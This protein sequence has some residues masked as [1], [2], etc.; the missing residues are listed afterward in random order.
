MPLELRIGEI[1]ISGK[2][3]RLILQNNEIGIFD[4]K[5]G[6]PATKNEVILGRDPQL[7]VAA[8]AL[9]EGAFNLEF[10]KISSLNYW[11]LSAL[12]KS[13]IKK[14]CGDSE[15]ITTLI[16]AAKAGLTKLFEHFSKQENGYISAPDKNNYQKNEYW[17]LARI[18]D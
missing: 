12:S 3:D 9:V 17:H 14:I 15:E 10:K 11:K 16:Y 1:L 2:V 7:T 18:T 8:L 6:L 4:Y 13:E 5:T